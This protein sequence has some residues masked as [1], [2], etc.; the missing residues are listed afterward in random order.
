MGSRA[1]VGSGLGLG[2]GL[3]GEV[4]GGGVAGGLGL[5][6]E[7]GGPGGGV[8]EVGVPAQGEGGGELGLNHLS[9]NGCYGSISLFVFIF[10][11]F[12][13]IRN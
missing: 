3:P 6:V 4:G 10:V 7:V 12:F 5:A 9:N 8:S 1:Q 2:L 13:E 11:F